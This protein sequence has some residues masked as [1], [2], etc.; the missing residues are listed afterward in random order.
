[1]CVRVC[2]ACTPLF[3]LPCPPA[4]A[5][6]LQDSQE[7]LRYLLDGVDTEERRRLKQLQTV[8]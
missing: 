5:E 3:S 2:F 6:A 8:L 1:M 4:C 7:L